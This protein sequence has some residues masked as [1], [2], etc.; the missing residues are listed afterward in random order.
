MVGHIG[1]A[2]I[3]QLGQCGFYTTTTAAIEING[4]SFI[5]ANRLNTCKDLI[6]RNIHGI[7]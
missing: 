4:R 1:V 5:W 6:V 2:S 7:L 3:F